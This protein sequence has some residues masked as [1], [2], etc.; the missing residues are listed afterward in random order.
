M[1]THETHRDY[2]RL[3]RTM[4]TVETQREQWRLMRL[5]ETTGDS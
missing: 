5:T 4:G 3:M 2:W 1:R